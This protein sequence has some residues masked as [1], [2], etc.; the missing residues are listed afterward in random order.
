MGI[1]INALG[2]ERVQHE[3]ATALDKTKHRTDGY[4]VISVVLPGGEPGHLDLL[5]PGEPVHFLYRTPK[6][7]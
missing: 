7:A 1:S 4:K 6:P 5:F 3:A 2:A